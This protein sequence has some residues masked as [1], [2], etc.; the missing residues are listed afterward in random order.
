MNT[1]SKFNFYEYYYWLGSRMY[2]IYRC[3]KITFFGKLD[4]FLYTY[5]PI[6]DAWSPSTLTRALGSSSCGSMTAEKPKTPPIMNC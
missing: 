1:Y 3:R 4:E 6:Q 5:I 2:I